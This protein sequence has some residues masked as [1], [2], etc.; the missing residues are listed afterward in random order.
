MSSEREVPLV[1]DNQRRELERRVAEDAAAT[2]E[3][4]DPA[5]DELA[6]ELFRAY[7]AEEGALAKP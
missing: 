4:S 7:D 3:I 6:A 1:N 5:F 2:E